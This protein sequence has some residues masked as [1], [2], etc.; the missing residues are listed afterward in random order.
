MPLPLIPVILGVAATAAAGK[1]IKDGVEAKKNMNEAEEVNEAASAVAKEAENF[2]AMAKDKSKGAIESLGRE[3]IKILTTSINDFI[4]NFEKIKNINLKESEGIDEL[5]NF[6]S[7]SENFK[8]LKE[9]SFEAKE[10]A[11]NG[12]AAI[13]SGALL[14]YGTY[15]VVMS[16]LGG[17]IVTA[18]TGTAIGT[19][20]GAAAVNATLAWLGGGA[21]SAGGFG[22]A[23]GMAVLGG[24]VVGPALAVGGA[25]FASKSRTALNDSYGNYD[26]AIAFKA[27]AKNIGLA[28]KA[29][30]IRANQITELLK[31][32][33]KHLVKYVDLMVKTL[34]E[35]G[36]DWNSYSTLEKQDIYKCVQVAQ[37]IKAILDTSLLKENG[38]LDDATEALIR[39]GENYLKNL[40]SI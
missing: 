25:I 34:E 36:C 13:G 20:S 12:L 29:V 23:G 39:D 10:I 31:N 9:A 26:K 2:I 14:A 15:S 17:V 5:K 37:T 38:E 21:L 30:F 33:D 4:V 8:K 7:S 18:T 40:N 22:M 27:Q 35:K 24:L 11:V 6:D 32:L 16:G 28:L 3:K 1:G 19:L